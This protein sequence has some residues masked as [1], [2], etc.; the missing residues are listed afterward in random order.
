MPTLN[1]FAICLKINRLSNLQKIYLYLKI[2]HNDNFRK[3]LIIKDHKFNNL[4]NKTINSLNNAL[5]MPNLNLRYYN[6]L[7]FWSCFWEI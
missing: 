2:Y 7:R 3:N 4:K 6:R 5:F 1:K